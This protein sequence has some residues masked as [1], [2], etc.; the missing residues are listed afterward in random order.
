[1]AKKQKI[2]REEVE[3]EREMDGKLAAAAR[4]EGRLAKG[5][6]RRENAEVVLRLHGVRRNIGKL[7]PKTPK[8][9]R[10]SVSLHF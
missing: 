2:Y 6:L 8:F 5:K 9:L 3:R 1:M 7:R 10:T 4:D